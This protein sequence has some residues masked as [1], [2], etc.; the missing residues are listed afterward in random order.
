MVGIGGGCI[1]IQREK[2]TLIHSIDIYCTPNTFPE[3]LGAGDLELELRYKQR[4]TQ[5][6]GKQD[7]LTPCKWM[8]NGRHSLTQPAR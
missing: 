2:L 4:P 8:S 6:C 5:G 1:M 3:V 7:W